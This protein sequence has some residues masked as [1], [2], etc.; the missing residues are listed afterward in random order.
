MARRIDN[1][2]MTA[3]VAKSDA[4]VEQDGQPLYAVRWERM[5]G[6]RGQWSVFRLTDD[7]HRPLGPR[8][9][10]APTLKAAVAWAIGL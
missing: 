6:P 4:L 8:E 9:G 10:T 5:G 7:P 2:R 1:G 3:W